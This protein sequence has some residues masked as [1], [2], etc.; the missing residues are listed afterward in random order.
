MVWGRAGRKD[1]ASKMGAT[2]MVQFVGGGASRR[3]RGESTLLPLDID[4]AHVMWS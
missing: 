2:R 4:N 3:V 1:V